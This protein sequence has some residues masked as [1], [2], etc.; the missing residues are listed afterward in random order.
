MI[1]KT[2]LIFLENDE[3][4]HAPCHKQTQLRDWIGQR[5]LKTE[6]EPTD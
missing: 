5:Q 2:K 6:I 4:V 3:M 1:N